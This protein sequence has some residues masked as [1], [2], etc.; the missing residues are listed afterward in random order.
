[1][2]AHLHIGMSLAP[3]WLSGDSW[4]RDDSRVEELYSLPFYQTIAAKAEAAHLDFLFLPDTLFLDKQAVQGGGGFA[5]LDPT[6]VLA[7]LS[8]ATSHIGLLT[9]ASTT[10]GNPYLL[11]RQLQTMNWLTQGRIGWNI[12]TAL[13][14][15]PNFGLEVMPSS[16]E[17]YQKAHEFT[18][19][20]QALWN[21][22]PSDALVRDRKGVFADARQIQ[23]IDHQGDFYQVA[24][25][26]NTPQYPADIP[27]IQAGASNTGR[28][29]AASIAHAVF[30]ATP[31]MS[32]AKDLRHD[33]RERARA[34]GRSA[35][36]IRVLPGL[37]LYLATTRDEAEALYLATH[38]RVD[39]T[40]KIGF[41]EECTGMS[42][43]QWPMDKPITEHDLPEK[44]GK[45]RS[46]THADLVTRLIKREHLTLEALLKRPE[47]IGSAHWQVIGTV[48][49]AFN[50]ISEWHDQGAIDGFIC[51]PGGSWGSVDL[52]LTQL[53]PRLAEAGR[54]RSE[55]KHTTFMGH[56]T[57]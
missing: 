49:D 36:D 22:F 56:L 44:R 31:D 14:G 24:G 15:Q 52:A 5:G 33:L 8:Q 20:V 28:Q 55:Y 32:V 40:R 23:A 29:F 50:A 19:V 2:P 10:F 30:A 25:P 1:M 6:L 47:V 13:G 27:L 11:A 16:D 38:K 26:L 21:S 37:S 41:I 53:M 4:R 42:L 18:E 12:V 51:T 57:E 39:V 9:T 45:V 17:R 46:Q 48:D 35:D 54:L 7:A 34:L 3:T 43:S